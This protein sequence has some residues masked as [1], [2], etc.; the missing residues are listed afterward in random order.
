M[1]MLIFY[2]D[3]YHSGFDIVFSFFPLHCS[4]SIPPYTRVF[5]VKTLYVTFYYITLLGSLKHL[6][7]QMYRVAFRLKTHSSPLKKV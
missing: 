7:Y 6:Q 5:R 2:K 3:W 4:V 1:F